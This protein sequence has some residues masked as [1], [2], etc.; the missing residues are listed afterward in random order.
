MRGYAASRPSG[1]ST[2]T[3]SRCRVKI[4]PSSLTVVS[5][6]LS[7]FTALT[8]SAYFFTGC[9]AALRS[10]SGTDALALSERTQIRKKHE[11]AVNLFLSTDDASVEHG[12]LLVSGFD[13]VEKIL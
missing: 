12:L 2:R 1:R 8:S 9:W 5:V 7:R 4:W 6:S 10:H 11:I 13:L 3:I